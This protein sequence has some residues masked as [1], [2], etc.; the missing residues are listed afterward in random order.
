MMINDVAIASIPDGSYTG[1]YAYGGFTYSVRCI[2]SEGRLDKVKILQN[3]TTKWA[4]QAEAVVNSV[5][6]KQK[7]NV[8][9][10]S[11]ATATSKALLKAIEKAL[12]KGETKQE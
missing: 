11:G 8:D 5:I 12:S 4:K 6:E 2:V 9:A 1:S 10:V 3:R 7:V